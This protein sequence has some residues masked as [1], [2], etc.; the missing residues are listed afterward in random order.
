MARIVKLE[1]QITANEVYL[2]EKSD[3]NRWCWG[4]GD[5]K[6]HFKVGVGYRRFFGLPFLDLYGNYNKRRRS[7]GKYEMWTWKSPETK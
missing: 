2:A 5:D 6:P 4:L 7:R 3:W 1:R